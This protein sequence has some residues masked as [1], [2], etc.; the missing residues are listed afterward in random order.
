[1]DAQKLFLE[2]SNQSG[3]MLIFTTSV[4]R[5]NA[6]ND[7]HNNGWS[8]ASSSEA[9]RRETAA[10]RRRRPVAGGQQQQSPVAWRPSSAAPS[11]SC[12]PTRQ[13]WPMPLQMLEQEEEGEELELDDGRPAVEATSAA[14]EE[15]AVGKLRPISRPSPHW[16]PPPS[17]C[18]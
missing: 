7:G 1:M 8:A 18:R 13:R 12:W 10:P 16:P 9:R 14:E 17:T 4:S 11:P 6:P 5:R 15:A 2:K 3:I